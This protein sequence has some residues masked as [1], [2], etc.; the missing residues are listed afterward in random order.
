MLR[1]MMHSL[2]CYLFCFS[3]SSVYVRSSR[4]V[5]PLFGMHALHN[6]KHMGKEL[7]STSEH[8]WE[9][10]FI[11]SGTLM[12]FLSTVMLFPSYIF[13]VFYLLRKESSKAFFKNPVWNSS[14]SSGG[15]E[16]SIDLVGHSMKNSSSNHTQCM[17]QAY[18][19]VL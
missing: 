3:G 8:I 5:Y 18:K 7:Y 15:V 13:A 19:S 9:I 1:Y 12:S 16:L 4:L 11:S 2:E 6:Y 14:L 17:F 10:I